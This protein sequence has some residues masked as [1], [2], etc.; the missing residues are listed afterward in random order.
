MATIKVNGVDRSAGFTSGELGAISLRFTATDGEVGQGSSP[1][2][3]PAGTRWL[4]RP[5]HP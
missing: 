1:I 2:P 4:R 5:A 3:D